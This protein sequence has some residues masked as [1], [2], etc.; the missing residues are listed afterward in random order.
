MNVVEIVFIKKRKYVFFFE[1]Y[2]GCYKY[3]GKLYYF[4]I[5]SDGF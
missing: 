4:I 3:S 2:Y 5:N 1:I